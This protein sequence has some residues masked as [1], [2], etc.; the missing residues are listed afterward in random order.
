[1]KD[2]KKRIAAAR[3]VIKERLDKHKHLNFKSLETEIRAIIDDPGASYDDVV[4]FFASCGL[5]VKLGSVHEFCIPRNIRPPIPG[6]PGTPPAPS[7]DGVKVLR[8]RP[9]S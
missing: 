1:M 9:R 8:R 7:A 5:L 2:R 3:A 4:D 6:V